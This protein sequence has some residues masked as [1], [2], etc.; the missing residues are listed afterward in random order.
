[1]KTAKE[2][3]LTAELQKAEAELKERQDNIDS[4]KILEQRNNAPH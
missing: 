1:L 3:A 2:K 4:N